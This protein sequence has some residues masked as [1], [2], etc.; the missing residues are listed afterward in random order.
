MRRRNE[1]PSNPFASGGGGRSKGTKKAAP[2][3][4]RPQQ[5]TGGRPAAMTKQEIADAIAKKRALAEPK[6][7]V[8][9]EKPVKEK[10]KPVAAVKPKDEKKSEEDKEQ[11]RIQELQRRSAET[12][13][14]RKAL[15]A[16]D[17]KIAELE[18]NSP[19]TAAQS[20]AVPSLSGEGTS[21]VTHRTA[22]I[23]AQT[24]RPMEDI[25]P[26]IKP[27]RNREAPAAGQP[28]I[29]PPPR[30]RRRMSDKGGGKQPQVRKLDRR[31]YLEYKYEVRDLLDDER[32]AEEH[33]S[34]V[35]G[36][37]WA[38]GERMGIDESVKFVNLKI[39]ELVVPEDIGNEIICLIRKFTT[40]R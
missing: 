21:V 10:S 3:R 19:D 28:A 7:D 13:A 1:D 39:E 23:T 40:K 22:T 36:Q 18:V 34:N 33:R 37:V 8:E 17:D 31:K 25:A 12:K 11:A 32:I 30:R 35:L 6:D 14:A 26:R 5:S 20:P 15:A 2:K 38:K 27:P 24:A 9:I 16:E 29:R 4:P